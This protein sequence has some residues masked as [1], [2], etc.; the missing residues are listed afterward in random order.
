ML[1]WLKIVFHIFFYLLYTGLSHSHDPG[2]GLAQIAL[3][4]FLSFFFL[5]FHHSIL[6]WMRI[7]LHNLF[8]FA[9]YEVISISWIGSWVWSVNSCVF[10]CPFFNWFFLISWLKVDRLARANSTHFSNWILFLISSFNINFIDNW[11]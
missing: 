7:R 8:W 6:G 10:S 1:S 9:F 3:E 11:A 2:C 4:F 5:Q